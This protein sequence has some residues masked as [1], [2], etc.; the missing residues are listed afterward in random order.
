MLKLPHAAYFEGILQVRDVSENVIDEILLIVKRDARALVT[1]IK[2]V[3]GGWDL[4][5]SS[6]HYLRAL[7]K[8]LQEKHGGT[9]K[10]TATLHTVSKTGKDLYRITVLWRPMLFK[11]GDVVLVE[12]ENWRVLRIDNQVQ[13]QHLVSGRK[14]WVKSWQIRTPQAA[15]RYN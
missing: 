5:F 13:L 11:K 2:K 4:Y 14:K 9:I 15:A 1:K 10:V 3:K 7:G 6:Q 12:G 8:K